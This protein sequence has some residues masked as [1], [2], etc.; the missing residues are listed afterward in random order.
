MCNCADIKGVN[1]ANI[2]VVTVCFL[3]DELLKRTRRELA[4]VKNWTE[5]SIAAV[6]RIS[7]LATGGNATPDAPIQHLR[8]PYKEGTAASGVVCC[9]LS[10]FLHSAP[11]WLAT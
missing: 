7:A 2:M 9:Q 4:S 11:P 3:P 10:G 5:I 1:P 6:P 8:V